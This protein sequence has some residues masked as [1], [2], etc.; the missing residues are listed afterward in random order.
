MADN[1]SNLWTII[2]DLTVTGLT[3]GAIYALIAL[4]YTLVYGVLQLINF[5]H[6]EVFLV[7]AF[8]SVM[9]WGW[10]GYSSGAAAVPP[11]LVVIGML[12]LGA[13]TASIFSGGTALIIE[14]VAYRPLR[15]KN[16]P[17]LIFL[18]TAIGASVAISEIVGLLVDRKV[19]STPA[20]VHQKFQVW[21]DPSDIGLNINSFGIT[22][23]QIGIVLCAIGMWLALDLF[24][25][26]TKFGLGIRS[27][28]QDE[29]TAALM[30]VNKDRVIMLTFLL[31]GLAAGVAAVLY[32]L[33]FP[34]ITFDMGFLLG[35]KAFTA[36]VL[37]GIGNLR[38]A[39][40]GGLVLGL[41]ENWGAGFFGND[42][43]NVTAFVV[44]VVVLMFRPTGILGDSLGKA[45]A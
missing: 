27:V 10:L 23:L 12:L 11:L 9:V 17:R 36:A 26:R 39:L 41:V 3:Q 7:G 1:F 8:G 44:L 33:K 25:N 5:A 42:W 15:R 40:V 6:S 30:G 45:R 43:M 2:G 16:A 13:V 31:G 37:G 18:I 20:L 21:F 24:L 32:N 28:A 34:Q 22:N 4:G 38:G 29:D 35:I 14:R 19:V